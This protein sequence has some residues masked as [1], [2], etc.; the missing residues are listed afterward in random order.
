A[1]HN[2]NRYIDFCLILLLMH[3][4]IFPVSKFRRKKNPGIVLEYLW[5]T[6]KIL[7]LK[8]LL[9]RISLYFALLCLGYREH[10]TGDSHIAHLAISI[11]IPPLQK[12]GHPFCITF[13]SALSLQSQKKNHLLQNTILDALLIETF[14]DINL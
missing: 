12:K 13:L 6:V 4:T 3:N 9:H 14:K 10:T 2:N 8:R 5:I 1:M 7:H 11:S